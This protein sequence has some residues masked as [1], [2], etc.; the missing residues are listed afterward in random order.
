MALEQERAGVCGASGLCVLAA[1]A[2]PALQGCTGCRPDL[3][4]WV[5]LPHVFPWDC[6]SL[7]MTCSDCICLIWF[8]RKYCWYLLHQW[9]SSC[10]Q[11]PLKIMNTWFLWNPRSIETKISK[12][13]LFRIHKF[14]SVYTFSPPSPFF[15]FF[16]LSSELCFPTFLVRGLYT[17]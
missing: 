15:S 4:F 1:V 5:T 2:S 9:Q 13:L 7:Q 11:L 3:W 10:E 6:C 16:L 8:C 17:V 12:F 14:S